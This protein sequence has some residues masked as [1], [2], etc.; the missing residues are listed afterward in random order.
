MTV[1]M[2]RMARWFL[3]AD[4]RQH[5]SRAGICLALAALLQC[6]VTLAISVL[7]SG[8][9]V[10]RTRDWYLYQPDSTNGIEVAECRG[11]GIHCLSMTLFLE[12]DDQRVA[13]TDRWL[14]RPVFV[15]PIRTPEEPPPASPEAVLPRWSRIAHINSARSRQVYI[16]GPEPHPDWAFEVGVGWPIVSAAYVHLS[17]LSMRTGHGEE[18]IDGVE[19]EDFTPITVDVFEAP[20]AIP[21]RIYWLGAGANTVLYSAF[22]FALWY[23]IISVRMTLRDRAGRCIKCGYDLRGNASGV[24]PECGSR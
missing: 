15:D 18:V 2:L 6:A 8:Q 9:T 11:F 14:S 5:L 24:C 22:L 20:C 4:A 13:G 3:N 17:W 7:A 1:R 10:R 12:T 23:A 16:E 19:L 21:L